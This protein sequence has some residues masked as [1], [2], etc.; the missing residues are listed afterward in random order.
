[1]HMASSA[2]GALIWGLL[3]LLAGGYVLWLAAT[4]RAEEEKPDVMRIFSFGLGAIIALT[5]LCTTL[6]TLPAFSS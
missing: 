5:G 3:F 4:G 2:S 1:M 6:S